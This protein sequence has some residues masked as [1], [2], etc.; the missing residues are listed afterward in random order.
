MQGFLEI[1]NTSLPYLNSEPTRNEHWC[2]VD[3]RYGDGEKC[4]VALRAQ[5]RMKIMN[6]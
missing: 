6:L 2:Q 4:S 5:M 3:T 1:N